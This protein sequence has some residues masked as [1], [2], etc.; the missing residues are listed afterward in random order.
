MKGVASVNRYGTTR[1]T[2]RT[3]LGLVLV[4]V[5]GF[6]APGHSSGTSASHE[7]R[8]K[9]PDDIPSELIE[10]S[11]NLSR[12][13][14]IHFRKGYGLR[15]DPAWLDLVDRTVPAP[16]EH[17]N[18]KLMPEE[19]A[20]LLSRLSLER[21]VGPL[22]ATLTPEAEKDLAAFYI[23]QKAGGL[24]VVNFVTNVETYKKQLLDQF[25]YPERLVVG[26]A[27]HSLVDL[28]R[29]ID[30]I[31][32]ALPRDRFDVPYIIRNDAAN[33]IDVEVGRDPNGV[34]AR[35][36]ATIGDGPYIVTKTDSVPTLAAHP[37]PQH[38]NPPPLGGQ[39]IS[40][41]GEQVGFFYLCSSAFYGYRDTPVRQ[42]VLVTAGH[43]TSN[44]VGARV[45]E[46]WSIGFPG[47]YLLGF[48]LDASFIDNTS[49]DSAIIRVGDRSGLP[50]VLT[51]SNTNLHRSVKRV[52]NFQDTSDTVGATVC[53]VGVVQDNTLQIFQDVCGELRAINSTVTYP[54]FGSFPQTTIRNVRIY[55][56]D[57]RPGV[58]GGTIRSV[59]EGADQIGPFIRP[60]SRAVGIVSGR[61]QVSSCCWEGLYTH[62]R[63]AMSTLNFEIYTQ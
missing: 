53:H 49:T 40:R 19:E 6:A 2:F 43:C 15:T 62:I 3:V 38:Q 56:R 25:P 47:R 42:D 21:A 27:R 8:P 52:G 34:R 44:G 22:R 59:T 50:E 32:E 24:L 1:S 37:S 13:E 28:D 16:A 46:T 35:L 63:H 48:R 29:L 41:A 4:M 26:Y 55:A 23:D 36:E 11:S 12:E 17:W 30:E 51:S 33:R 61:R 7:Y 60:Y 18:V 10:S 14:L 20:D 9:T 31:S 57:P 39:R 58:S 45:S 5:L 54:A